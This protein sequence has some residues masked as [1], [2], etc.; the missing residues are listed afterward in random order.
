MTQ[1]FFARYPQLA[2]LGAA[3]ERAAQGVAL[4]YRAGK[5]VLLCGNG[6]SAADC[7]HA[8]GELV[9]PFKRPRPLAPALRE[10]LVREGGEELARKL[11][12]GVCCVA[13]PSQTAAFT[14]MCND[15]GYEYAFAQQ[16]CALGGE[17]D[18]LFAFS[19]SGNSRSVVNAALAARAVGMAATGFTGRGGGALGPLCDVLINVPETE[20]DRIQE[21]HLPAYHAVCARA[22]ELI[23]G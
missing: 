15:V 18:V 11:A 22:E 2:P 12:G 8:A 5:K 4:A 21:L 7:G 17:G 23:W 13:L 20:T 16:V 6:G 19:T 1:T 3:I 10:R 9:K 14:A